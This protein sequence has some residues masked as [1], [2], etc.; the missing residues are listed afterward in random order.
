MDKK[1]KDKQFEKQFSPS[2]DELVAS[3]YGKYSIFDLSESS[4]VYAFLFGAAQ[5]RRYVCL[6]INN[7]GTICHGNDDC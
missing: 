7:R 4:I 6:P 2:F 1:D 5:A 3:G